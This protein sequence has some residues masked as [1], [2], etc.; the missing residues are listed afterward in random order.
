MSYR[1]PVIETAFPD[2]HAQLQMM[3]KCTQLS[4]F[5]QDLSFFHIF[6]ELWKEAALVLS[7]SVYSYKAN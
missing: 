1:L 5:V 6:R 2:I 4:F 7:D 3:K